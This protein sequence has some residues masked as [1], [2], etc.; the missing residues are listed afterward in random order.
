[1]PL[2]DIVALTLLAL[3]LVLLILVIARQRY[4]LRSA[5]GI[6]MAVAR[7]SR[8]LYG[9]A[10]YD[11]D[12]LRWYRALGVGTR[13]SRI[14]RRD[15]LTVLDRR[16]PEPSEANALPPTAVVVRCSDGS[17]ARYGSTSNELSIAFADGAY[18]GFVSWLESARPRA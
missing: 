12:E 8:W 9:V 18:T 14:W 5:G 1:M 11:G 17:T 3:I 6:A 4:M 7:G 15:S 10:R 13:P 16:S 2:V